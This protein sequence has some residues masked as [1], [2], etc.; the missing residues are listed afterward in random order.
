M[1]TTRLIS[2][3]LCTLALYSHRVLGGDLL[4]IAASQLGVREQTGRN[5]GPQVEAYWPMCTSK[6][7]IPGA[8]PL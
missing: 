1:A 7:E 3:L 4:K 2:V 5:D 8:Q 6:K